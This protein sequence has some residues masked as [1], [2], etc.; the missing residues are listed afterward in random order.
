MNNRCKSTLLDTLGVL[1]V[2]GADSVAFL[3]GQLS[4]DMRRLAADRAL[5]A[6]Y[7]NPQGR[8][9][10]LLRVVRLADD[11][12]LTLLPRELIATV[13]QRLGK[14]ILRSKV[15]LLED[16]GQWAI[17]GVI[18]CAQAESVLPAL[19][20]LPVLPVLPALP[21]DVNGVA[22]CDSSLAV[23][24]ARDPTRWLLLTPASQPPLLP[25]TGAAR[26]GEG[27]S[28]E[29]LA[30]AAG[31]PEVYAR[32]SEQFVAQMLN[33]DLLGAIA[34]DKGCYTGQEIIARA[35]YR[36]RVKRRLQRFITDERA[37]LMP[38]DS[39]RLSDGRSFR[40]VRAARRDDGRCELLAV[41]SLP[42]SASE[43]DATV[44]DNAAASDPGAGTAV[45]GARALELPYTLPE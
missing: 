40:V 39:G 20:V 27:E 45:L 9:I 21:D 4:N 26:V 43:S 31:E 13:A 22:R 12:L 24:I 6:G 1:R 37:Q 33:L 23:C 2:R 18:E 42:G 29:E 16:S 34:F 7:H 8:V 28:W 14:F 36:G 15:K 5:L 32:T 19:P 41:T 30:I 25:A 17:H 11:D 35:H 44:E 38:G 3:Q 10:A